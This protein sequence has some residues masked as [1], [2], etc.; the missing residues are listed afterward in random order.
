M[1]ISLPERLAAFDVQIGVGRLRLLLVRWPGA[2]GLELLAIKCWTSRHVR[3][4][5][6]RNK[7]YRWN[8]EYRKLGSWKNPLKLGKMNSWKSKVESRNDFHLMKIDMNFQ[9]NLQGLKLNLFLR[10]E[11]KIKYRELSRVATFYEAKLNSMKFR[12][13]RNK[14]LPNLEF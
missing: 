11:A 7:I 3:F 2:T 1:N 13:C 4:R 9:T 5:L 10:P 6:Q 14:K 12:I 8:L